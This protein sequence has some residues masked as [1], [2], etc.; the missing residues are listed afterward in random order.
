MRPDTHDHAGQHADG[1]I[2]AAR[3]ELDTH[4]HHVGHLLPAQAP[5]RDFVHH[6]TLHAFQHLPFHEAVET[7]CE[8]LETQGYM[9]EARFRELCAQGRILP[10]DLALS[11]SRRSPD[12]DAAA[13]APWS[14]TSDQ[15]ALLA[16]SHDLSL[17]SHAEREWIVGESLISPALIAACQTEA[18]A[19]AATTTLDHA[20]ASRIWRDVLVEITGED[21][22]TQVNALLIRHAAAYL[23]GGL[24]RWEMP[25]RAQGFW[26]TWRAMIAQPSTVLPSWLRGVRADL[27]QPWAAHPADAALHYMRAAGVRHEDH[28]AYILRTLLQLPGWGGM[29]NRLE[30]NP[31][32]RPEG[33]PPVAL[34]DLLAVRLC[35]DHFAARDAAQRLLGYGEELA[36]LGAWLKA[37]PQLLT[38]LQAHDPARDTWQLATIAHAAGWTP[39]QVSQRTLAQRHAL[40]DALDSFTPTRRRQVFQDAYE[41]RY[42]AQITRALQDRRAKGLIKVAAPKLQAVFCIDDREEG[43]RRHFEALDPSYQTFGAAGFFGVAIHFKGLGAA[44][45]DNL[46]P[47]V[48]TPAHELREVPHDDS[49]DHHARREGRR[50]MLRSANRAVHVGSRGL[51]WGTLMTPVLGSLSVFPM[52]SRVF[53]PRLH[54]ALSARTHALIEG[55]N[56]PTQLTLTRADDAPK[57]GARFIGFTLKEQADRVQTIL[58]NI[59]LHT[60]GELVTI[61]AH[62]SSSVNNPHMAAYDC[63]A[64]SGRHGGPNARAFAQMANTPEVRALLAERGLIIPE[65]TWFIGSEHDTCT[66]GMVYFDEDKIPAARRA[67]FQELVKSM[68]IA[69]AK[70]A[71]ERCRRFYSAPRNPSLQAALRH[72]EGRSF[73]LS[74]ARP[75]LGH[76]TNAACVVG[77]RDLTRGLFMDRRSFLVCYDP[78]IDP[79]AKILERTLMAA[80]PVGAGINLEYYFSAV[81]NDRFGAG[82]KLPHNLTG[83]LGVMDGPQSDLRTGLP[84]QMIESHEPMRLMLI[85]ETM[86][87]VIAGILARQPILMELAANG[88]FNCVVVE[89]DSGIMHE[90]VPGTGFVLVDNSAEPATAHSPDSASWYSGKNDFLP[91]ATLDR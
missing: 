18:R 64:C 25:Q 77:R 42:R 24:A 2:S 61:V 30:H 36:G 90:F 47:V 8:K 79:D 69:R 20:P 83:L 53:F 14:M 78:T 56:V 76:M 86:P 4:L 38:T 82:T 26:A 44:Q 28:E 68:D 43:I 57:E 37:Q 71:H 5:L 65:D 33:A 62:G 80:G 17:P 45:G 51:V 12:L 29:F 13:L 35:L 22:A 11:L 6:N 7:A 31:G 50:A 67:A 63:G 23:D 66:D 3:A 19:R 41:Q 54:A 9:S 75:E 27:N 88:W 21:P 39:E 52:V 89:P 55:N 58:D 74:Q 87:D 32:D 73:D 91:F 10:R 34:L 81:D 70:S 1:A 40:L 16:L 84:R 60:F 85:V 48:V 49:H 59:G 72:V 15:L 46:C